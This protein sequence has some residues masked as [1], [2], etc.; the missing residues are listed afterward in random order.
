LMRRATFHFTPC[1][2]SGELATAENNLLILK[3]KR[4][5]ER[6]PLCPHHLMVN[7]LPS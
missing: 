4:T 2:V 3:R 7:A 5:L 1:A 6:N